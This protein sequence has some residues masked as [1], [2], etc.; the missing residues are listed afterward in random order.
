MWW[1]H[2]KCLHKYLMKTAR[3]LNEYYYQYARPNDKLPSVKRAFLRAKR[4]MRGRQMHL[5]P[6]IWLAANM[7]S[8]F[9]WPMRTWGSLRIPFQCQRWREFERAHFVVLV[10]L[11][12][13][14]QNG[15]S[16]FFESKLGLIVFVSLAASFAPSLRSGANDATR[17]TNMLSK[18]HVIVLLAGVTCSSLT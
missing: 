3:L 7:S 10:E 18:S 4:E 9:A 15:R 13:L 12:I 6:W 14:F 17:A 8:N 16:S 5:P 1:N 2:F 11:G